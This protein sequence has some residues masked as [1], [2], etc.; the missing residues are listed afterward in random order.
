MIKNEGLIQSKHNATN[1]GPKCGEG[2]A[3]YVSWPVNSAAGT[4]WPNCGRWQKRGLQG[5]YTIR[6]LVGAEGFEPPTLCSQS[7]CATRLR[8]A[9]T[10]LLYRE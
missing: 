3:E 9:P 8:Y 1:R 6:L 7:R 10:L 5:K 2:D 4:V